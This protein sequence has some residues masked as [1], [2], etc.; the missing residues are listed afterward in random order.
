MS[1]QLRA[2]LRHASKK[3]D[4]PGSDRRSWPVTFCSSRLRRSAIWSI[5]CRRS[6][7]R[8]SGAR[9]RGSPGWSRNRS[10]HWS[11]CIPGSTRSF[12][13]HR[14]AGAGRCSGPS[15]WREVG[16]FRR[17]LQARR[18]DHI[19]D[20]QGLVRSAVICRIAH[21]RSHGYDSDSIRESAASWLYDVQHRVSRDLHAIA[22]NRTLTGLALDYVPEGEPNFGID[23]T[24]AGAAFGAPVRGLSAR[25]GAAN[26]GM[27]EAVLDG[28]GR[29]ARS[30]RLTDGAAVGNRIRANPQR[31]HCGGGYRTPKCPRDNRLTPWRG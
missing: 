26:K 3:G 9:A 15:T 25:D 13:W 27:A 10:Y 6:R 24:C 31:G 17:R 21:G 23:R 5:T 18:Y 7:K 16:H 12:R 1:H 11:S 22:R 28:A 4:V 19:I 8:D 14:G 20:T 29:S 2:D 30:A